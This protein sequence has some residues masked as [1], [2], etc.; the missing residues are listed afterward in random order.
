MITLIASP[1]LFE[2]LICRLFMECGNDTCQSYRNTASKF[3][4][5]I[6]VLYFARLFYLGWARKR[7]LAAEDKSITSS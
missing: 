4:D 7:Q 3:I 1:Y 5:M 6:L 2:Y